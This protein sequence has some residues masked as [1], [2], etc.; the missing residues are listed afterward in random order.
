MG[1]LGGI[2]FGA[3]CVDTARNDR[4]LLFQ[5]HV[6]GSAGSGNR[7]HQFEAGPLRGRPLRQSLGRE[8]PSC[9]RHCNVRSIGAL[10]TVDAKIAHAVIQ[11]RHEIIK[12]R[13]HGRGGQDSEFGPRP[14]FEP[15]EAQAKRLDRDAS[16]ALE[17]FGDAAFIDQANKRHR[18]M[19]LAD[20]RPPCP[21]H[22]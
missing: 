8:R 19:P 20:D 11:R 21:R 22:F 17:Q 13:G 12:L 10:K 16:G 18:D 14:E 2:L 6:A 9:A 3:V 1:A 7:L 5:R 4:K 15:V